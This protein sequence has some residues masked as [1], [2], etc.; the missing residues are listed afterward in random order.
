MSP[1]NF[2]MKEQKKPVQKT[3]ITPTIIIPYPIPEKD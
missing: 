1:I 3:E 2:E